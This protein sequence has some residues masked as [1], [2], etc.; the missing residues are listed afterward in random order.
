MVVEI[1]GEGKQIFKTYY[2]STLKVTLIEQFGELKVTDK[3]G[4]ASPKV[5]VKVF[6]QSKGKSESSFFRDGYTDIRGKFEY[7]QVTGK[8][9]KEIERFAILVTSELGSVIKECKPPN[10]EKEVDEIY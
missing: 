6:S 2:S 8:S 5:Y 3:D 4:K 1:N 9:L 10:V 7:A